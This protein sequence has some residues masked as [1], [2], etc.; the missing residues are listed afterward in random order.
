M[1]RQITVNAQSSI[2]IGGGE[3]SLAASVQP[4]SGLAGTVAEV[5]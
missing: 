1:R 2:R 4:Q 3:K 5:R